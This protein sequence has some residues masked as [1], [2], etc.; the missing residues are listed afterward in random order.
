[1]TRNKIDSLPPDKFACER[2]EPAAVNPNQRLNSGL[3]SGK[4]S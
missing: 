3:A 4:F 1:M 2:P